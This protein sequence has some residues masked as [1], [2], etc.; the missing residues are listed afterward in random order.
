MFGK[1]FRKFVDGTNFNQLLR[2]FHH[3]RSR[4]DQVERGIKKSRCPRSTEIGTSKPKFSSIREFAGSFRACHS[5]AFNNAESP[6]RHPRCL[7]HIYRRVQPVFTSQQRR[8][9]GNPLFQQIAIL[10]DAG[11]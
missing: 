6:D 9:P 4:A 11:A 1:L 10:T 3:R 2:G 7:R 5:A 8:R